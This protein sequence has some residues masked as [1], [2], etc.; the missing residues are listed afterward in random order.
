MSEPTATP[1][2][3]LRRNRRGRLYVQRFS[4]ARRL[5]HLLG[6]ATF[7]LLVA[8]GA[9][10]KFHDSS[11]ATS[12]L[13]LFGG[14]DATRT[15]HRIAGLVFTLHAVI[16]IGI[17]VVGTLSGRMRL[18]LLPT[19]QDMDAQSKRRHLS[20]RLRRELL[21]ND[22]ERR[23]RQAEATIEAL[24]EQYEKDKAAWDKQKASESERY[25]AQ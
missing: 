13:G 1:E 15:L 8:T 16:H 4:P 7:V 5:E 17:I 14:L 3:K 23:I 12:W 22:T 19:P 2:A 9:P 11:W 18:T 20:G 6:V 25:K 24:K 21:L 10:Q